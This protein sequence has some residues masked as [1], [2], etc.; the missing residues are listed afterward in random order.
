MPL[1]GRRVRKPR[2]SGQTCRFIQPTLRLRST[3][4]LPG[5]R[6]D[7]MSGPRQDSLRLLDFMAGA[8]AQLTLGQ[9]APPVRTTTTAA[10]ANRHAVLRGERDAKLHGVGILLAIY[11]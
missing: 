4:A 8:P 3:A 6:N 11:P 2:R 7:T 9:T 5:G 1:R 10:A